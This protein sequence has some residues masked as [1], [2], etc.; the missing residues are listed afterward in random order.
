MHRRDE[1]AVLPENLRR[2]TV[3]L[4][5]VCVRRRGFISCRLGER[6]VVRREIQ[7]QLSLS[8]KLSKA[9]SLVK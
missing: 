5:G 1:A 6:P 9:R 4:E 7:K 3:P 8:C 2:G